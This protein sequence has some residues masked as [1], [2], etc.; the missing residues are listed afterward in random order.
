VIRV[1]HTERVLIDPVGP[2][3]PLDAHPLLVEAVAVCEQLRSD[4]EQ[5]D[6]EGITRTRLDAVATAGLVT[7]AAPAE[8]GGGAAPPAVVR[9]IVERIAGACGTTWFVLTQHRSALEAALVTEVPSLHELWARRLATGEALGG[10]AFAHLRRPGPPQVSAERYGNSWRI[11]GSLDWV[12]GWGVTDVL[13]LMAQTDDQQVVEVLIPAR[14]RPGLTVTRPLPLMAMGGT[15]TVGAHLDSMVVTASEV[16]RLIPLERW[17]T[18]D[19]NR[20]VNTSPA[21]FG[22]IRAVLDALSD[23]G[24]RRRSDAID[25][26][27]TA[28]AERARSLRAEAYHLVDAVEPGQAHQE[29][30]AVRAASLLLA[31]EVSAALIAATGGAA[32]SLG[33]STQ[34][35]ARE[36]LF[37]LVQAQTA[38]L[39]DELFVQ[40]RSAATNSAA[41]NSDVS[42]GEVR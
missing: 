8:L 14:L 25:A 18:D 16:A 15:R 1:G 41:T 29:R 17:R 24:V 2:G 7:A 30:L 39:R 9:E 33:S 42:V 19:A 23:A 6:R 10:V 12:T 28:F 5:V 38:S 11:T 34:R 36:A 26:A 37:M 22:L 3:V 4:A 40:W 31:H 20:T 35:H 13:C 21:V 32:M 27:A